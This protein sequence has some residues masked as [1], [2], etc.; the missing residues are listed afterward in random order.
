M[1]WKNYKMKK[2]PKISITLCNQIENDNKLNDY[3]KFID[4]QGTVQ[5]MRNIK[6]KLDEVKPVANLIK[7]TF[8]CGVCR[9]M[10]EEKHIL[11]ENL[12]NGTTFL[13]ESIK[14]PLIS[15][16]YSDPQ[17]IFVINRRVIRDEYTC[18]FCY[19]GILVKIL[20]R[21][22]DPIKVK[23]RKGGKNALFHI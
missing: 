2:A 18:I 17:D 10:V 11:Q 5:A 12:L 22:P 1:L 19:I 4:T 13:N 6:E 3:K 9:G 23:F 20:D 15:F 14:Q 16:E 7:R 21:I 8:Y